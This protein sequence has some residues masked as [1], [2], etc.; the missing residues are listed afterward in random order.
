MSKRYKHGMN[1]IRQEKRLSIYMRDGFACLYC[2]T[3][4][5]QDEGLRLTLDHV[6]HWEGNDASNLVTC[7]PGC[8]RAKSCWSLKNFLRKFSNAERVL[9]RVERALAT[10]L[11]EFLV[12]AKALRAARREPF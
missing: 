9:K 11:A 12:E 10:D 4:I 6:K 7:C 1:W 5:E 3:G 8:N 2:G